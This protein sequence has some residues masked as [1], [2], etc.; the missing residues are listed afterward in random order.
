MNVGF[1]LH[2]REMFYI[3]AGEFCSYDYVVGTW[4]VGDQ[5]G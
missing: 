4:T 1:S 2:V 5:N 3:W